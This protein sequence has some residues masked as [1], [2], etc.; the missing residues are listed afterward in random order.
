MT[1]AGARAGAAH[2]AARLTSENMF[3]VLSHIGITNARELA[4]YLAN[5]I[6]CA[7]LVAALIST[8]NRDER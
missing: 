8:F 6:L 1:T 3:E 5:L 2:R 7:V 4:S